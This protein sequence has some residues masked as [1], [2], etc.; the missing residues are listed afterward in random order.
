MKRYTSILSKS[1]KFKNHAKAD[2]K[3][4][5]TCPVLVVRLVQFSLLTKHFVWNCREEGGFEF[6]LQCY[7]KSW[8]DRKDSSIVLYD[9]RIEVFLCP[10]LKS[11]ASLKLLQH[12]ILKKFIGKSYYM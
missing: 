9:T 2:I 1:V 3:V 7:G 6:L 11:L 4:F 12:A 8:G 10:C 5:S